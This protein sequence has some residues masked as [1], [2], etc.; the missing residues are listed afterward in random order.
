[1]NAP[2]Q[3]ESSDQASLLP[4]GRTPLYASVARAVA[5]DILSGRYPVG[6]VI[7][8][9]LALTQRYGVSRQTVRQALNEL[10]HQGLIS[11][12]AGIGTTVRARPQSQRFLSGL[13]AISELLQFVG[14]TRTRVYRQREV[15]ADEGLANLLQCET[16]QAW[17]E[18]QSLREGREAQAPIGHVTVYVRSEHAE[19]VAGL[20]L[21]EVPFYSLLERRYGVHVV[22]VQQTIEAAQL[23]QEMAGMLDAPAGAAALRIVRHFFDKDARVTQVSVGH[24]PELRYRQ[25]SRFRAVAPA[26]EP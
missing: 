21:V 7:P 8:S 5:G 26:E 14:T 15:V 9:E 16:G 24:Y 23:P 18:L 13:S 10:K 2:P 4:S 11:S 12:H 3:N 20:H 25:V 6:S 19:A 1:M 22:E 17:V